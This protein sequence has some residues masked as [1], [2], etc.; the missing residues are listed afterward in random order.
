PEYSNQQSD[1]QQTLHVYT[2]YPPAYHHLTHPKPILQHN[3]DPDIPHILK[4]QISH[5]T[6]QT[7][8]LQHHLKILLIP[9][10]PNHHNNL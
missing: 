5:L 6:H 10:H 7:Q 4:Q 8:P 2:Q 9:K 1:I 3:L